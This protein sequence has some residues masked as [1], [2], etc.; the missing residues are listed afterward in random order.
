MLTTSAIAHAKADAYARAIE[1]RRADDLRALAL[2][3]Q[4]R[5]CAV[6]LA[7]GAD[8]GDELRELARL[9]GVP[10]MILRAGVEVA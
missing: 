9:V 2:D 4:A 3:A 8:D 7:H 10:S 5:A 6:L 1:R